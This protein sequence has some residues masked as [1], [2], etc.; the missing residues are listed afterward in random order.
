MSADGDDGPAGDSGVRTDGGGGDDVVSGS[1][2]TF[3]D[4][5]WTV[6]E[7]NSRRVPPLTAIWWGLLAALVSGL[8]FD[9][10]WRF[11]PEI[12]DVPVLGL[13]ARETGGAFSFPVVGTIAPLT[14]LYGLTLLFAVF[15]VLV[16]LV[17]DRRMTM[18]YWREFRKNRLAVL[19][20]VW[21]GV[22][23]AIGTVGP[24][25]LNTPKVAPLEAY[26]PPVFMSVDASVPVSCVGEAVNG[27]CHGTWQHPFGTTAQGK[28][29]LVSV[30]YGM[31]ISMQVGLIGSFL[32]ILVA[33]AVGLLAAYSR[34]W[35]D[36]IL[37]RYVDIQITF[38]TFF[39]YL[40]I[41]F[42]FGGSLFNMIVIFGLFGWGGIARIV[43][44][45]ALQR[46]E[47]EYILAS[48]NTGA[49]TW[50]VIRRHLLP[51]VSNSVIT[52]VSL[53]IPSLIL[54]EA[55]LAFLGLGDPTIPSWGEVIA[56]GRRD[57]DRAAWISTLPGIFLFFTI[58][59]FN[60]V[61]DALRDA[62]DPRNVGGEN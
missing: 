49:G 18:Y 38:P 41:T 53:T 6:I 26:Q 54:F 33:S 40:L 28:D 44:S 4:I 60:F 58:L 9:A 52:A 3:E 21:L 2:R 37:M 32:I 55:A 27:R 17:R 39:L 45:E 5:D 43:R 7:A 30:I 15:Q 14:W 19:S 20:L 8:L 56:S 12:P 57:L 31:K 50:S 13:L 47:E 46:R 11:A 51:N 42:M 34:G 62:L 10:Y 22:I 35:M 61:G 24:I 59:A 48:E 29:I 1:R 36:E 16:P 23:F 25:F